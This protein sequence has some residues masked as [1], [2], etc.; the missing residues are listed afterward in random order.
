MGL[1]DL[2][3]HTTASDGLLSPEEIVVNSI[4]KGIKVIAI[5][6]H[7]TVD[8]IPLALEA[9]RKYSQLEVIPGIEISTDVVGGEIHILGYYV[10]YRDAELLTVLKK[11]KIS[12]ETRAV[13][14]IAKLAKMGMPLSMDRVKEL[15]AGGSIGRPHIAQVMLEHKYVLNFREA[16]DKYIG[17]N[18]PAYVE[19][20]KIT[21][22]QAVQ[23][24]KRSGALPVLAHPSNIE[25]L[26][27]NVRK[28]KD[29]G[30]VGLEVYYGSYTP[31]VINYLAGVAKSNGIIPTG[32]SD[33]HGISCGDIGADLGSTDVPLS[34]VER[35]VSLLD[36]EARKQALH[37]R[38][39]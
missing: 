11:L 20:E 37:L 18:G 36:E 28:L 5:T 6:D 12:R 1:V 32:G 22:V 31:E 15:S 26:E 30:L 38:D 25:N 7:D 29:A 16:F 14:I 33:F 4:N 13:K 3:I 27:D 10:N 35:L 17:H 2:H 8:G 9:A 34:S 19:R 24:L 39:K 21:P 23:L